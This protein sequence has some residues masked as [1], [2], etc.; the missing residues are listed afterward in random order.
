MHKTKRQ[1][2]AGFTMI[3]A[4]IAAMILGLALSSVLAISAYAFRYLSDIRLTA[5]SS[6]VLQQK[7]EDLRLLSWSDL[8]AASN[9]FDDPVHPGLFNGQITQV[10]YSTYNGQTTTARV[11]LTVTWA[12]RN[13]SVSTNS[14]TT[15]VANGGLNKYIF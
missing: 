7:M 12:N 8:Q 4:M 11:T 10:P 9:A 3:E 15:I 2:E 14:L 6:Q 1:S 5:R 13:S